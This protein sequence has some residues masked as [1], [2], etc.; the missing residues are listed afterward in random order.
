[1]E[2]G[3]E[4]FVVQ[5]PLVPSLSETYSLGD[6]LLE[7]RTDR[8]SFN[9]RFRDNYAECSVPTPGRKA[10]V[11]LHVRTLQED[12]VVASFEVTT[13]SLPSDFP[14][15]FL[16]PRRSDRPASRAGWTVAELDHPVGQVA[17]SGQALAADPASPWEALIASVA[18][19]LALSVQPQ[20]MFFHGAAVRVNGTGVLL[21]GVSGAGKTSL[22]L[23]LASRGHGF[24]GDDIVGVRLDSGAIVPLR[25]AAHVRPGPA[26]AAVTNAL[27]R[28]AAQQG[29]ER[30][31]A[32]VSRLF[33]QA[34]AE[35]GT[36]DVTV[37]LR[38]FAAVTRLTPFA[39]RPQDL[40]W[41]TPHVGSLHA[42]NVAERA[43]HVL[44]L[45][46]DS[47]CFFLDS[48]SPGSAADA[49]ERLTE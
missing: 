18:V 21:L 48:A 46:S 2:S 26:A 47:R 40:P 20:T 3:L 31:L 35:A 37:C 23:A 28:S 42:G 11:V 10:D 33:P 38:R 16:P 15:V 22:S 34:G 17:F 19:N 1:M 44:S 45:V 49:L 24:Y 7:V 4:G 9:D 25:R 29:A 8:R 43:M 27:D 32:D 30:R 36:L 14:T 12:A 13:A 5:R 39:P 6:A 41:V